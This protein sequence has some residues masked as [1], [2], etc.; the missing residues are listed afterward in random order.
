MLLHNSMPMS[1][2]K[3]TGANNIHLVLVE[4]LTTLEVRAFD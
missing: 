1:G 2:I 4:F 3:I